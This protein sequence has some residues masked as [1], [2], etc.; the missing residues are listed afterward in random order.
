MPGDRRRLIPKNPG[1]PLHP[2]ESRPEELFEGHQDRHRIAGET[3][4][5]GAAHPSECKGLGGLDRHLP[6][7]NR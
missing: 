7:P 6:E 4:K 3:E 5:E 2:E 1:R